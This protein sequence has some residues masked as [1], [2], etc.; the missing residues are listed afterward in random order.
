[1]VLIDKY[2]QLKLIAWNIH[3]KEIDEQMAL[4]LYE[5][6]WRYIDEQTLQPQERQ[7][8]SELVDHFG[9]GVLNV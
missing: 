9:K 3:T 8:I 2:P 4:D 1:M 6:N 7:L 5:L